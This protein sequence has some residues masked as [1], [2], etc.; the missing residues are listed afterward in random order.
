LQH[1]AGRDLEYAVGDLRPGQSRRLDLQLT[2]NRPGTITTV[3]AARGE[4][5]LRSEDRFRLEVAAPQLDIAMTGPKHRYLEREATY[6]V[7]ISNP[8][9]A[10]AQQVELVAYLPSG[11]KFLSANN[12]GHFEPADNAVHWRLEELPTNQQGVVEMVTMPVEPGQQS[13]KLRGTAAKGLAVEKEQ[14]VLIDGLAAVF[15]QVTQEANPI[16]VGGQTSYQ[17]HVVNQGSKA[18]SNVRLAVL[19]PPE[20]KTIAADGPGRHVIDGG[21]VMF[22]GV[23]R[24]APKAELAYRVRVQ[25]LQAGDL[26]VRCQLLT[27]DM[28]TPV[29]KEEGTQVIADQ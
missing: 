17:V 4:G 25:G 5:N 2:A 27:D 14:P 21:R 15:F 6:Q 22:D 10:P 18:A 23:D 12:S 9:T 29:T 20:L 1:P 8:G 16:E 28:Q 11:L 19:L 3:L 7:A 24:L 13:I 26:R